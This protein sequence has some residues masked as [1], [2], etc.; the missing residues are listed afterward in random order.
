MLDCESWA[1]AVSASRCSAALVWNCSDA[2][3]RSAS[4]VASS[5]VRAF[6]A[7]AVLLTPARSLLDRG[8]AVRDLDTVGIDLV[9]RAGERVSACAIER[10]R[11]LRLASRRQELPR[12]L[13]HP[14]VDDLARP[15]LGPNRAGRQPQRRDELRMKLMLLEPERPEH[16][17]ERALREQAKTAERTA[18][19]AEPQRRRRGERARAPPRAVRRRPARADRP[20]RPIVAVAAAPGRPT[21][22]L[23]RSRRMA[24]TRSAIARA[25]V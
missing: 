9:R 3:W 7:V 5:E 16:A 20:A 17:E 4:A 12:Q 10:S 19:G 22:R 1:A 25:E 13:A 11:R 18:L 15:L 14:R 2:P 6:A 21:T 8:H 23:R 24:A